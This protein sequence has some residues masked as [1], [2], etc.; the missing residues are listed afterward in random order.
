[1]FAGFHCAL[2]PFEVQ[3]IRQRNVDRVD[4]FVRDPSATTVALGDA[5]SAGN[6]RSTAIEAGPS[7]PQRMVFVN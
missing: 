3:V 2:G 1:M 5:T 4:L 7:T 6:V